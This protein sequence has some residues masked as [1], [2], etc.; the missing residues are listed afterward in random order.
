MQE[1]KRLM[2][3]DVMRGITVAGMILVNNPGSWGHIYAPLE[4]AEWHGLTP[5]DL[6]F[7]FFMFIMGLSM[8]LSLNKSDFRCD[9]STV[10]KILRRSI[11]LLLIG[12]GIGWFSRTWSGLQNPDKT[13]IEAINNF[14]NMRFMGVFQRLALC[15][16]ATALLAIS[17]KRRTMIWIAGC[18]LAGYTLLLLCGNGLEFSE[19]NIVGAIDRALLG[20][21]H[22]YTERIDGVAIKIDPE[23]LLST[24]PAI[25]HCIIGFVCGGMISDEKDNYKKSYKLFVVGAVLTMTGFLLQ[26]GMPINKKLWTPTFVFTTCGLASTLLAL[27]INVI[28]IQRRTSWCTFFRVF[29]TNP[30]FLYLLST[31][32][33]I[34]MIRIKVGSTDGGETKMALQTSIYRE[35]LVPLCQGNETLAS[36]VFALSFVFLNWIIGYCLYRKKI[37]IKI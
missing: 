9:K 4:H 26:Y 14:A 25:A 21:N 29:G 17:V 2:S 5:T 15:Y 34:S 24:L 20:E 23:G 37:F 10:W 11:V 30:L 31:I 12:W 8:Y 7:P 16:C 1:N 28:D 18:I 19:D 6:V 13:W 22:M 33:A 32:L 36:L 3:V 35:F 27:L